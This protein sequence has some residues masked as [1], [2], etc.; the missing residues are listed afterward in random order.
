MRWFAV[1]SAVGLVRKILLSGSDRDRE[2]VFDRR[3]RTAPEG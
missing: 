2:P 3:Q 1:S